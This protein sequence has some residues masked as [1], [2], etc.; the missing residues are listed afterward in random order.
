MGL[1]VTPEFMAD[2]ASPQITHGNLTIIVHK[3]LAP[4][5]IH[6]CRG[7]DLLVGRGDDQH[8]ILFSDLVPQRIRYPD[9]LEQQMGDVNHQ[10]DHLGYGQ[11]T[12]KLTQLTVM[13][14]SFPVQGQM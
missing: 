9:L 10:I 4:G 12:P 13:D 6:M 3:D 8:A 1:G 5:W 14:Q 2:L 11:S 7:L